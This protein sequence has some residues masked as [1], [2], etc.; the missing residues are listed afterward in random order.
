MGN[1]KWTF[2]NVYTDEGISGTS[3]K[4]RKGFNTMIED[5]LSGKIDLILTKSVSRFARNTVDTLETVRK[6]KDK[7]IAVYFEKENID[8]LDSKGELMITIMS[9][10]AQEESRSISENVTWGK[11]KS[12]ADGKVCLPY[13]TFLGYDKGEDGKP[14][15]NMQEAKT[16]RLIYSLYLDGY[17]ETK[18]RDYLNENHIQSPKVKGKWYTSRIKSI[19]TNEKYAGNAL[20]QKCYTVDFI[21]KKKKI[22]EGEV[23]QY[24]VRNSHPA[25][26][27]ET[28]FN[29]V[30][31]E[32][33]KR[34]CNHGYHTRTDIFSGKIICD[35]CG[36]FYARKKYR[37]KGY[38]YIVYHCKRKYENECQTATL[39]E[40]TIKTG[41]LLALNK[42]VFDKEKVVK[43]SQKIIE[44]TFGIQTLQEKRKAL[45]ERLNNMQGKMESLNFMAMSHPVE[46]GK[47]E[48]DFLELDSEYQSLC[49]EEKR[50]S[51]EIK[52]KETKIQSAVQALEFI[53]NR[54]NFFTEFDDR[55]WLEL[56]DEVRV[57]SDTLIFQ[58]KNNFSYKVE[59]KE[60]WG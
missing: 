39:K 25:I 31:K 3:T 14:K 34:K 19:L 36:S 59:M 17:T 51:K 41:F 55:I 4:K 54:D 45:I 47:Y 18:I 28:D 57:T 5:A 2:V 44:D 48:Q 38:Q 6:L 16:V 8:T 60:I 35:D 15:I 20:L 24:F 7:G 1:P 26:I 21:T 32:M 49:K 52:M 9:S 37:T 50:V 22:N 12:F 43:D 58:F 40:K 33:E 46:Q 23:P 11:R 27:S 42:M 30:Q 13:K 29:R 53:K 10:L 56:L